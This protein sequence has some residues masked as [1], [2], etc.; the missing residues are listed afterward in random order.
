MVIIFTEIKIPSQTTLSV[1]EHMKVRMSNADDGE[2]TMTRFCI[3]S[4]FANQPKHE[5]KLHPEDC[6]NI[7]MNSQN[8]TYFVMSCNQSAKVGKEPNVL[9]NVMRM[10]EIFFMLENARSILDNS[11][12]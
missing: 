9:V 7:I 2:E 8:K 11:K 6:K 12:N 3:L 10:L 1:G 5:F 4:S